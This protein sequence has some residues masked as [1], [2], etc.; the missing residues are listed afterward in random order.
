MRVMIVL[1]PADPLRPRRPDPHF[2]AEAA[3][4]RGAGLDVA[5]I[6]HDALAR[7]GA[8]GPA[9]RGVPAADDAVYRGWMLRAPQYA[10][11]AGALSD[12]GVVLR[13]SPA[14]Y[15]R[16]HE[17]PGWYGDIAVATPESVWTT[18]DGRDAFE[19]A[20]LALGTGP[21][22][23]RDYTK[24]MKHHWHEAAF[25]PDLADADA[26]WR[27]ASR[28]RSLRA[29]D[30]DGGYVLRRFEAFTGAEV[31]TWWVAGRC[32][33]VTAHPDTSDD[34]PPDDLDLTGVAPLI[35]GM[36]LPFVTVDLAR[37]ADGRWR[38]VEIGDGQVSDRPTGTPADALI[39]ALDPRPGPALRS[40]P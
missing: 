24:S 7:D 15:A 18:G 25:V 40:H 26:A 11:M 8:A 16:A 20:R 22:V 30:F 31:R 37:R 27:V 3:A 13:T 39:T 33:L 4:A 6:D 9:V 2:A 12:R 1:L 19:R 23:L 32:R 10:A 28:F 34:L 17:L 21:A 38:V 35:R 5:V 14:Q 36:D 29:D